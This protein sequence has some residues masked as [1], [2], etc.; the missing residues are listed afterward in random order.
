[1]AYTAIISSREVG[2]KSVDAQSN[3][4]KN[5]A[6]DMGAK[7]QGG[8]TLGEGHFVFTNKAAFVNARDLFQTED[9]A[10]IT[11]AERRAAIDAESAKR[12]PIV[13]AQEQQRR[14]MLAAWTVKACIPGEITVSGPYGAIETTEISMSEAAQRILAQGCI[15]DA[16]ESY[17]YVFP[18]F[19][20]GLQFFQGKTRLGIV[21]TA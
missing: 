15:V 8:T 16:G 4:W 17:P 6:A 5:L 1:M 21:F 11:R 12:R 18:G 3:F 13:D 10:F 19:S 14:E 20:I 7:F 9:L 2:K